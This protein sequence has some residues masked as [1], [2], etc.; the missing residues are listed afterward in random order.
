MKPYQVQG[1]DWVTAAFSDR[2]GAILADDMGLG[3]TIQGVGFLANLGKFL[4]IL[5]VNRLS[6][7][8][9]QVQIPPVK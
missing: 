7:F 1:I 2:L 5:V 3:K 4:K 6:T 9:K 8:L